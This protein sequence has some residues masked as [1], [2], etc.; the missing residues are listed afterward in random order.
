LAYP[1]MDP[2]G[3]ARTTQTDWQKEIC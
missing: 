1:T 3:L 2:Y